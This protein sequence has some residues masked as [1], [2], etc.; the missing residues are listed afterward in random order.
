MVDAAYFDGRTSRRH[1]VTLRAGPDGLEIVGTSETFSV[2][3]ARV[4]VS[5]P[6]GRAPRTLTFD[7]GAY[8]EVPQGPGLDAL[9]G[10]LGHA[11]GTV[12][13][14]QNSWRMVVA[15][16]LLL[17]MVLLGS[18]RWGLPWVAQRTAEL[19]PPAVAVRLSDQVIESLDGR[20][21]AESS[22]EPARRQT[23]EARFRTMVRADPDLATSQ[24][25]WRSAPKVGPNAFAL[26][27]GRI[28]LLD[29]L[30]ALA[31]SDD[32]V[33][34]VLAHE[35]GHVRH[36]HGV[37]Q[38]I[39]SSVVAAVA[40]SY[41]GD[42]SMLLSGLGT[43]LLESKYSRDFEREADDYGAALLQRT[44]M[45]AQSLADMLVRLQ[46]VQQGKQGSATTDWLASHP[47]T[48]ERIAR[49][50]GLR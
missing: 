44:G 46:S 38:L 4:R 34:A 26:P 49:L 10:A 15:G 31:G 14:W 48:A 8:C 24:L 42:V 6:I 45:S 40:A 2:P 36:R 30:V 7:G 13:R 12:A 47:E 16:A 37:R 50:R 28:V 5:E 25:L 23:L 18:Y 32:E 11:E 43:L 1:A 17:A 29:Q 3:W 39:Q 35:L 27:D 20:L 33:L 41:L 19:M 22:V 21:L 9:L